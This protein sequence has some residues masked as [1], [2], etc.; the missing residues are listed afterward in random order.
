MER[1]QQTRVRDLASFLCPAGHQRAYRITSDERDASCN[2]APPMCVCCFLLAWTD[3]SDSSPALQGLL[4]PGVDDVNRASTMCLG[5]TLDSRLCLWV[6]QLRE[7]PQIFTTL[8]FDISGNRRKTCS[9][10]S[11]YWIYI[12]AS[13]SKAYCFAACLIISLSFVILKFI[14]SRRQEINL[15]SLGASAGSLKQNTSSMHLQYRTYPTIK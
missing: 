5:G 8:Q 14:Q 6:S 13:Y 11:I 12:A 7:K 10:S 15:G 4:M 3:R 2:R 9:R 1:N